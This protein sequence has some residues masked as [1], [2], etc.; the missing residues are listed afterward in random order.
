MGARR[1]D[2]HEDHAEQHG[3]HRDPIGLETRALMARDVRATPRGRAVAIVD[4]PADR[5]G[6]PNGW[7]VVLGRDGAHGGAVPRARDAGRAGA[8]LGARDAYGPRHCGGS[9]GGRAA[10][11]ESDCAADANSRAGI[12]APW[13]L[14]PGGQLLAWTRDVV[15]RN[16]LGPFRQ[17]LW[18]V[19]EY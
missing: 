14:L 16:P 6:P 15:V 13:L 2:E 12:I 17:K 5:D 8:G 10:L 3:P 19:G 11:A 18:L 1:R 7:L 4:L 9:S